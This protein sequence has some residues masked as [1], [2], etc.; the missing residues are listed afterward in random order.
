MRVRAKPNCSTVSSQPFCRPI[1]SRWRQNKRVYGHFRNQWR[2]LSGKRSDAFQSWVVCWVQAGQ[3]VGLTWF[4]MQL[5]MRKSAV[6]VFLLPVSCLAIFIFAWLRLGG[7]VQASAFATKHHGCMCV[8]NGV[9]RLIK[10]WALTCNI[11]NLDYMF[12][13]C[14]A[15][16]Y[17]WL[18][19][20]SPADTIL[21]WAFFTRKP[22][23]N[24]SNSLLQFVIMI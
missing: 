20:L 5:G 8:S 1:P 19:W 12:S 15:M 16:R 21:G 17:A 9:W 7:Q 4:G 10:L 18:D 13:S 23:L 3:P 22:R 14:C 6:L 2:R 11:N 24:S